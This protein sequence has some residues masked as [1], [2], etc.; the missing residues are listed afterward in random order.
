VLC[1]VCEKRVAQFLPYGLPPRPGRCPHCGAK[2]RNRAVLWY[3]REI[4][5][6]ALGP[7]AEILEVGASRVAA[8]NIPRQ[9][10]IGQAR[11]TVI[12][13]RRLAYHDQIPAPH[14]YLTMTATD[15]D[16][17]DNSFDL[18]IC[19]H[20]LQYIRDDRA[21]LG[22]I[23]RCLK[24]D[25][26]A[27]LDTPRQEGVTRTVADYRLDHPE[28]DDAYFAENGDQWVYGEDFLER[29]REAG[30]EARVDTL[31]ADADG[32]YKSHHGLKDE[33]ELLLAFKSAAG[34]HR[35]PSPRP[36]HAELL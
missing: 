29:L 22:E 17:P 24:P 18:I 8:L 27:M 3:L 7:G 35:F 25:G 11:Y 21:A 9:P 34:E 33:H 15:M 12:D 1:W 31:F 23:H 28:L 13:V 2:P 4:V 26:L 19:N 5:S 30:L 32:E 6:P 14:R 10:V 36:R 20:A 16:F